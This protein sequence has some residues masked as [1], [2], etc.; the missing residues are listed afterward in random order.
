V[1]ANAQLTEKEMEIR[2]LAESSP[3]LMG[4]YYLRPDGSVCMPY[5]S[6]QIQN[7]YGLRSE[8][9]VDDATSLMER[10]HPD[11]IDQVKETIVESARTMTPWRHEFRVLHPTRGELWLEG[12]TNPKPHPDG[13]T[14]WYGFIHDITDRKRAETELI[15]YRDHL[16]ELV[17]ERTTELEIER[18]KVQQYMDIA[19]VI[20]IIIDANRQVTLINQKGCEVLGGS[21]R[22]IIGKDWFETFVPENIR[23]EVIQGFN[24]LLAGKINYFEYFENPILTLNGEER[25]IAWH[26]A[27]LKDDAGKVIGTLSS[28]EDITE[29]KYAETQIKKL[30]RDLQ[31]RALA[32][33]ATNKELEAFS[34]SVS[35]DLRAPLRGIDGFSQVL[36]DEYQDKLDEKGQNY[37]NRVRNAAQRMAQLIDDMLKLSKVSRGKVNIRNINLSRIAYEIANELSESDPERNVKFII[38]DDIMA[39]ADKQ[40]LTI[41]LQNLIGNAWKFTSKHKKAIIEFGMFQQDRKAVYFVR[42][43]GVGFNMQYAQ[44]LFGAFQRLHSTN[45]FP[46]TGI[47]LAT[48]QRIIHRHGGRIWAESEIEKGTTIYFTLF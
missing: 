5:T 40:L 17:K 34:Y 38:P 29:Q 30:N 23:Q 36:L 43:D 14:I 11:D 19:G 9:V 25:L 32:L 15:K 21:Y 28:G 10:T 39:N 18:N 8:D 45:E 48:V 3:G 37:L 20:L 4:T 12:S 27:L 6:P 2:N 31:D 26:N 24:K 13:G 16:E 7:L 41:V 44:K 33:E 35:H 47:G 46:G 42:D 1:S 22:D